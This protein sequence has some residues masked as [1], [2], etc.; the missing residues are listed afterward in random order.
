[1]VAVAVC[2][3]SIWKWPLGG[4]FSLRNLNWSVAGIGLGA[5]LIE[6]GFLLS[7]RAGWPLNLTSVI[8]NVT[9]AV[10]LLPISFALFGERLSTPKV[11]G[12]A[13]CLAGLVLISRD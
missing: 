6:V 9:A 12:A 2:S 3:I 8:V 4:S 11:L 10:I 13:L 7:Y 5:A 1:V